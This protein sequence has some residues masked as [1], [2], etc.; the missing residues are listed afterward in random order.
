[1]GEHIKVYFAIEEKRSSIKRE[2]IAGITNYFT[3]IYIVLLVPEILI[4]CFPNSVNSAGD[5]NI[6][7]IVYC[8]MTAGDVIVALTAISLIIAG[9]ASVIVGVT[10]NLPL[11]QG[12]S[13]PIAAFV[14]YTICKGFGY[15]YNQA[16]GIV[17]LS[18]IMFYIL[19]ATGLEEKIHNIIP[20]N[21]KF[22]VSSGIGF[23]IIVRGLFKAHIIERTNKGIGLF[24]FTDFNSYATLS[25]FLAIGGVVFIVVLLKYRVHAA[26]FIGKAVCSII[27]APMGLV[28]IDKGFVYNY[29][30]KPFI[31][32]MDFSGIFSSGILTVILIVFAICIM[33]IFETISVFIAMD[34]YINESHLR[35]KG[36]E[37]PKILEADAV[38]SSLSAL[39]GATSVS[40]YAESTA[41]II[42]GGRTGLTAVVTGILFI[43]SLLFTPILS[44]VP[45]AATATTLIVA[46]VMM[47]K[48]VKKID[49]ENEAEAV[50]A[51][52]AMILMPVTDSILVGVAMGIIL[53][54]A[55]HIL[56]PESKKADFQLVI[57][58]ILFI[59]M[60]IFLP[61]QA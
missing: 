16:L 50:P 5:I 27:A 24:D 22:A 39:M 10:V 12:P 57:L 49:F 17:F 44:L 61:R 15:S 54:I 7:N 38:T 4:E 55:V 52:I 40:A 9:I 30:I 56:L 11:A 23:F 29:N 43:I 45:S 26:V 51:I 8:N 47:L 32:N 3:L 42:E 36:R 53:Y 1:M 35:V 60:L 33:D 46:G 25:A 18:G 14:T 59:L 28:H 21:I 13:L 20:D 6:H 37:V 2:I 31:I 48:S 19:S 34:S 58:G 41:G